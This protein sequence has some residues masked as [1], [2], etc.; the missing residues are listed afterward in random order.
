MEGE[1]G[2]ATLHPG[3][4]SPCAASVGLTRCDAMAHLAY[5][6]RYSTQ[7]L[8]G[9]MD[10]GYEARYLVPCVGPSCDATLMVHAAVHPSIHP[11]ALSVVVVMG[12]HPLWAWPDDG[13]HLRGASMGGLC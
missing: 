5:I 4:R 10:L 6:T 1:R 8:A 13:C 7:G 9:W 11:C 3:S 2:P 12:K